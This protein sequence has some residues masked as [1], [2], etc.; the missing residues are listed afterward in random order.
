M[1]GPLGL[2]LDTNIRTVER[3]GQPA[4]FGSNGRPWEVFIKLASRHP[5]RYPVKDLGHDVWN[6]EGKDIDPDDNLVQL[7]ITT[8]RQVLAPLGVGVDHKRNLGYVL[9]DNSAEPAPTSK[10]EKPKR[11]P[12]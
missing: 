10:R 9:S 2:A 5:A 6:P 3:D 7:A 4:S 1:Q 8:V 11:K 12:R